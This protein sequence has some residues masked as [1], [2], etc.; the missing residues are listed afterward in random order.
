[1]KKYPTGRFRLLDVKNQRLNFLP[2]CFK[3]KNNATDV[4]D[5]NYILN[6]LVNLI[7]TL[8]CRI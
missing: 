3:E 7:K 2:I 1:M 6:G 5:L 4:F 8:E